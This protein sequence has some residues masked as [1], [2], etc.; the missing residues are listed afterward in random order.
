MEMEKMLVAVFDDE[1]KAYEGSRALKELDSDGSIAIHAESVVQKN[2]DGT[3]SVK[4]AE[5]DFPVRTIGGTAIGTLIGL[6]GGPIGVVI[7]AATGAVAG[8]AA[9]MHV[10]GVDADF[11]EDVSKKLEP[12]KYAV[13]ADVSEE[14][15]TPVDVGIGDLGGV[16]FRTTKNNFEAELRAR[17]AAAQRAE[18]DGLK[19]EQKHARADQKV[20]LQAKIDSLNA[21]LQDKQAKAKQRSEQIKSEAEAKIQALEKKEATARGN[22]KSAIEARKAEIRKHY[23]EAIMHLKSIESEHWEK[24]AETL[25]A[26][27]AMFEERAKK[28]QAKDEEG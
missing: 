21:K 19:M 15:V 25:R 26:E 27:A 22:A 7:G 2:S 11:I 5:G 4:N 3:L 17:D 13:V 24:R 23:E 20:K 10:A 28:S 9:D 12:G 6:L 14:W 8:G 1:K 16:I 18:I